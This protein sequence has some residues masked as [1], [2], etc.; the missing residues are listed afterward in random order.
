M[1]PADGK[2]IYNMLIPKTSDMSAGKELT[3]R[4][5]PLASQTDPLAGPLMQNVIEIRK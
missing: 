1:R 5:R 3:I 4:V 2:Y